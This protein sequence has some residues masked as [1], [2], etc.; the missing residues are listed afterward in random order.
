MNKKK[1]TR[2]FNVLL[3]VIMA[4]SIVIA[5]GCGDGD[6][7]SSIGGSSSGGSS[8]GGGTPVQPTRKD[9]IV[10]MTDELSGLFNPYY[11]TS[12]ADMDVVGMTQIGMLSTDKNGL[13]VAGENES[14]VVL[15]FDY[16]IENEGKDNAKTVYRIK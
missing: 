16:E 14:T 3:S 12:G 1:I 11:A 4:G 5:S 10:I 2:F 15:D 13:P 6:E 8:S 7:S 9:S